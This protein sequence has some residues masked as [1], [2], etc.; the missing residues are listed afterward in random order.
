MISSLKSIRG[1]YGVEGAFAADPLQP[2]I[3]EMR[4]GTLQGEIACLERQLHHG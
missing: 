2:L 3:A 4:D 1:I